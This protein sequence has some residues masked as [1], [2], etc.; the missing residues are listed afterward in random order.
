MVDCP[1][2]HYNPR[3]ET[4]ERLVSRLYIKHCNK[5]RKFIRRINP[6]SRKNLSKKT[7]SQMKAE[8][9]GRPDLSIHFKFIGKMLNQNNIFQTLLSKTIV[10]YVEDRLTNTSNDE[11]DGYHVW[12]MYCPNGRL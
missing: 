3:L 4:D 7:F 6:K 11:I 5:E 12:K 9:E 2:F 1:K 10:N 8:K